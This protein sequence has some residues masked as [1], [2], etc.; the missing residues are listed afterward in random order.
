MPS[1]YSYLDTSGTGL[2]REAIEKER[3]LALSHNTKVFNKA[4]FASAN[5]NSMTRVEKEETFE[6]VNT[7]VS[8]PWPIDS[9][10]SKG[11]SSAR[12]ISARNKSASSRSNGPASSRSSARDPL[13]EIRSSALVSALSSARSGGSSARVSSSRVLD[14]VRTDMSTG[15]LEATMASLSAER[16]ALM[17]RLA[18]VEE[19][20]GSEQK[21]AS[22]KGRGTKR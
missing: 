2:Y 14:S 3:S 11:A 7:K 15:R 10:R 20:L 19:E 13:E 17:K 5:P 9:A 22:P 4:A 12:S 16:T 21:T 1:D 18:A 8:P 6:A